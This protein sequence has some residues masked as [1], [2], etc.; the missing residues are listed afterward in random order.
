VTPESG[1]AVLI[2][3]ASGNLGNKLHDH[4][5]GRARLRL[6]DLD[7]R[8]ARGI[9][10]ADLARWDPKW[11]R[12]FEGID[13]VVH[14]AADPTAAQVWPKLVNPNV[15]ALINVYEAAVQS[16]VRRVV[17]ASSNHVMGGYKELA[18][19][20]RLTTDLP[21]LPGTRYVAEGEERWSWAYGSGKLF[22]ERLGR[23]LASARGLESVAL[24]LGWIKP[25]ENRADTIPP[26]RGEWFRLMWLSN[27]DYCHLMVRAIEAVLPEPFVVLNGMSANTGMRWDIEA[28]RRVLGYEPKDDVTRG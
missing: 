3:G 8:G 24:R 2:T 11:V 7:A 9:V 14:L 10:A 5:A 19:P 17:F 23:S 6:I 27:R 12:L 26:E 21:P 1:R 13:T 4:L 16:G 28:T 20:E 25:G 18:Q 22:G 15:D